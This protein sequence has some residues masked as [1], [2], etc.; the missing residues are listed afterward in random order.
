MHSI[1]TDLM[2]DNNFTQMQ[3]ITNL[4]IGDF[5]TRMGEKEG[6]ELTE[7]ILAYKKGTLQ[8]DWLLLYVIDDYKRKGGIYTEEP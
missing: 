4:C 1:A 5:G 2:G 6:K 3:Y 7:K 8:N